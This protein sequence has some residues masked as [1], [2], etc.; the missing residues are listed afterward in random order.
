MTAGPEM[1]RV[2]NL[3]L[4]GFVIT[5]FNVP[6]MIVRIGAPDASN[7]VLATSRLATTSTLSGNPHVGSVKAG[8]GPSATRS[9]PVAR[10]LLAEPSSV[11]AMTVTR[12]SRRIGGIPFVFGAPAQLRCPYLCCRRRSLVG[13]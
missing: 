7:Q 1:F 4:A 11:S 2:T 5:T 6:V 10:A 12:A 3:P 13:Y 8:G 9:G